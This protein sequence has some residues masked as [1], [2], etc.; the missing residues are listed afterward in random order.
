MTR[1]GRSITG[2]A[3]IAYHRSVRSDVPAVRGFDSLM[4]FRAL[5][6]VDVKTE[7]LRSLAGLATAMDDPSTKSR[8]ALVAERSLP[9]GLSRMY[10]S[11]RELAE[12]SVREVQV[13]HTLAEAVA[14]AR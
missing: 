13:F 8:L 3:L 6:E 1:W 4:D 12:G 2:E 14:W 7:T 10:E 11:F 5:E 9:F